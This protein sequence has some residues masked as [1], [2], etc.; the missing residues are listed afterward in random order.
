[1]LVFGKLGDL[2][3]HKRIFS[4]GLA[5]SVITFLLCSVAWKFEFLLIFRV[6]QGVSAALVMSCGPAI[7]TSLFPEKFRSRVL[8][9]Y[10]TMFGIGSALGPSLGGVLVAEWDWPAVFWFRM[11]IALI[12]L[13]L[14]WTL[15]NSER[16]LAGTKFDSFGAL[17]V[18]VTLSCFLL[19]VTQ[20]QKFYE[21]PYVVLILGLFAFFAFKIYARRAANHP[22]PAYPPSHLPRCPV[23]YPAICH[24]LGTISSPGQS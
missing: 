6:S 23:P 2:Y 24:L 5:L 17:M 9:A 20:L 3:G 7:A 11:P 4:I 18:A 22:S 8:G 19:A 21:L 1:M 14:V 16:D 10:L 15:P 13:L 12:A